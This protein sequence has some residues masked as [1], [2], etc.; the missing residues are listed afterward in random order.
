MRRIKRESSATTTRCAV[1]EEI[2]ATVTG[3][4]LDCGQLVDATRAGEQAL[5]VEQDDEAIVDLGDR[6]DRLRVGGW[7]GLELLARDGQD[8]FDV[9]D[10]DAGLA[11]AGLDDDDLAEVGVVDGKTHALREVIDR[12]DLASEA[13]YTA[14]PRHVGRDGARFGVRDDFVD[15]T[16][17]QRVLLAADR[18]HHELLGGDVRHVLLSI[19]RCAQRLRTYTSSSDAFLTGKRT[20]NRAPRPSSGGSSRTVP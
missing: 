2:V 8:L 11:G 18:E 9:A 17:G 14:D 20:T 7:D 15:G 16:D 10:E 12:D 4:G 3:C 19:G 5:G 6:L 1:L 13:D